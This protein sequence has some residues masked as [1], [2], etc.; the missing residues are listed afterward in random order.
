MS[1][2]IKRKTVFD[3]SPEEFKELIHPVAEQVLKETWAKDSF[4]T[5]YDEKICPDADTLVQEYKDHSELVRIDDQGRAVVIKQLT[6]ER[7]H[8][9][10]TDYRSGAERSR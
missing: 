5:Y 4:I 6:D 9:K 10:T 3:M 1:A 2:K 8:K 7:S